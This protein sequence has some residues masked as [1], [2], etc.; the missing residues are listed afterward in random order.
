MVKKIGTFALALAVLGVLGYSFYA[1][2][3]ARQE[4]PAEHQARAERVLI[5]VK[6]NRANRMIGSLE[7]YQ[8]PRTKGCFAYC[9]H[10]S[11]E[12]FS[13]FTYIPCSEV[14]PGQLVVAVIEE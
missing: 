8:D 3:V 7:Y 11:G 9:P 14:P 6:Q 5:Q 4:T 12:G 1:K 2:A 13:K 10:V